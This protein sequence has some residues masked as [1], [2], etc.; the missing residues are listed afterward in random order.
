MES[1][2]TLWNR[3][4]HQ[5]SQNQKKKKKKKKKR[6]KKKKKKGTGLNSLP[7]FKEELTPI[8][9]TLF[10]KIGTEGSLSYWLYDTRVTVIHKAHLDSTKKE[11]SD[12]YLYWILM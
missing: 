2:I 1:L 6:K 11:N 3:S 9:L 8:L 12:Q 7:T 10:H 4:R 5:K